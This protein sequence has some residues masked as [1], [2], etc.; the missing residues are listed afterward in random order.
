MKK[1]TDPF[2]RSLLK[3]P[4][5]RNYPTEQLFK[6]GR[7]F[8]NALINDIDKAT[9]SIQLE[10]Y[11]YS[12]DSLGD[13]FANH[14]IR[15]AKR[16]VSVR[17]L[18]DGAGSPYFGARYSQRFRDAG[19]E[20]QVY[21][22]FPWQ[23]WHWS[24]SVVKLPI[25]LKLIYLILKMPRRN[26]RKVCL[27]DEKIAY[28]GSLNIATSHLPVEQGGANWRD[29]G[30]RL[31][32]M[33]F[34]TLQEALSNAW[35]H[36]RIREVIKK[37]FMHIRK[38]PVIRLNHTRHRRRILH[39]H[40]LRRMHQA[41]R[42]I[43]ITNSYFIPDNVLLHKLKEAAKRGIDVRILVP[44]R[45]DTPIRIE[46]V[47]QTLYHHLLKAGVRIFEY[48]PTM[49][50]AKSIIIDDWYIIGS[51]N[52]DHLS[53]I[54]NLEVDVRLSQTSSKQ[55]AEN[56]FITDLSHSEEVTWEKWQR[57]RPLYRR[58]LGT[59]MFYLKYWI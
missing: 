58:C 9:Q 33:E 27:I 24:R 14:L 57:P 50:H 44:Q 40:L 43:W 15:A 11:I 4:R 30:I 5:P 52:L 23:F 56:Q 38:D 59:L 32:D 12:N 51:S 1:I 53:L 34:S 49:L 45:C 54:H 37:V 3:P 47:V 20:H 6:S 42:R 10:T 36:R 16:G 29:T 2:R 26:H 39:K 22:P 18:V 41:Q 21:H 25:A 28:I 35:S 7:D 17:V 31:T 55:Q 46:W 19:V 48:T 13:R 8:F